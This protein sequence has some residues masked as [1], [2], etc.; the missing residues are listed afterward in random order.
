M[1]P[2]QCPAQWEESHPW[3]CWTHYSG[4]RLWVSPFSCRI[5]RVWAEWPQGRD[6]TRCHPH[7]D[8]L[9][10]VNT[11]YTSKFSPSYCHRQWTEFCSLVQYFFGTTINNSVKNISED[12]QAHCWTAVSNDNRKIILP[13]AGTGFSVL[14]LYSL[15]FLAPPDL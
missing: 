6:H 12:V 9:N 2:H 15:E 13:V 7:L 8:N 3:S 4:Y 11:C 1:W 14:W 5:A 10:N